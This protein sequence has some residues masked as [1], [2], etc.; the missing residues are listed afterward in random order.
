M[1]YSNN[2]N[3]QQT[4]YNQ[5]V[6]KIIVPP[7]DEQDPRYRLSAFIYIIIYY[8]YN[9]LGMLDMMSERHRIASPACLFTLC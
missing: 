3:R 5:Q 1:Y 2:D 7:T 6:T 8:I 9:W 4:Q